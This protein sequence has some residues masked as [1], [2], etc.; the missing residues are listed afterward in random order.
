MVLFLM[1]ACKTIWPSQKEN[2]ITVASSDVA[3]E[4]SI[5]PKT[6]APTLP[7]LPAPEYRLARPMVW[8]QLHT[9]LEL[10][11]NASQKMVEGVATLTLS[12][13]RESNLVEI[14]ALG[15]FFSS[16]KLISTDS[17]VAVVQQDYSDSMVMRLQLNQRLTNKDTI[18]LRF[19]YQARPSSLLERK[20]IERSDQQGLYFINTDDY[21]K[22]VQQIWSQG[23]TTSNSAWF[24]CIDAPNQKTTQEVVLTV[25]TP[26]V[27]LSNGRLVY[28]VINRDGTRTF[29]WKQDRPHAPY[30]NMVAIGPFSI[31]ED[32]GP[33]QLPLYYYVE[34]TYAKH[35]R[36]IF[37]KTPTIISYFNQ[38]FGYKYPWDKYAQVTVR[39][40]V[41]GAMENTSATTMMSAIQHDS[42]QHN[43]YNYEDYI[44]HE[45]AHQWFGNLVTCESWANTALNEGFATYGEYLW[46]ANDYDSVAAF[47]KLEA[48]KRG[49]MAQ[50]Q[51]N[52]HPLIHYTYKGADGQM[53]DR[54]SYN[55]GALVI[56][57]LRRFL[58]DELFFACIASYLKE[59]EYTAVDVDHLRHSFE[60][61]SGLD[62]TA[63]FDSWFHEENHPI[64]DIKYSMI[65]SSRELG[66]DIVQKQAEA[67]YTT[68]SL[69]LPLM[70]EYQNGTKVWKLIDLA[71]S[72]R[73]LKVSL[74]GPIAY[75]G[76]STS[77]YPLI[78]LNEEKNNS[79]WLKGLK[80]KNLEIHQRSLEHFVRTWDQLKVSTKST[81]VAEQIA[82][83]RE[84]PLADKGLLDAVEND[85]NY[86]DL[87]PLLKSDNYPLKAAVIGYLSAHDQLSEAQ[88][89]DYLQ[90]PSYAVKSAAIEACDKRYSKRLESE[91]LK[92]LPANASYVNRS[93]A[94]LFKKHGSESVYPVFESIVM[95][96]HHS[97]K[98]YAIY[99][100]KRS[101]D[102]ILGRL[103]FFSE[104]KTAHD[105]P[106]SIIIDALTKLKSEIQA[107]HSVEAAQE[108]LD[109]I[110]KLEADLG[111]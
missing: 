49:Y 78:E 80:Q 68:Y 59:R 39:N 111:L 54:H 86:Y 16:V 75:V 71:Q 36:M 17:M 38:A 26:L 81:V 95:K 9:K 62:L 31:L 67:G 6:T 72:R 2:S 34:P 70:I 85:S 7:I 22:D 53:F 28:M 90:M 42:I 45:I 108:L 18:K 35:A 79:I 92:N 83:G 37:E 32:V 89:L 97:T 107:N 33:N 51:Y 40:F 20:K 101:K 103:K 109:A 13:H 1:T 29:R 43:D 44:V 94:E 66:I 106:D 76:I 10:S 50:S 99:L 12:P 24:P 84:S 58:G 61:T 65:D 11:F 15:M 96:N 41:S 21:G 93:A 102:F 77:N 19:E 52:V 64:L 105:W 73:S 82:W 5:S 98:R 110:D 27:A 87:S 46:I 4:D 91:I 60:S 23:E 57:T 74:D 69:S 3:T 104:L 30:L 88:L 48:L 25:D 8:K 56:H 47:E 63:F 55:K 14:D 100:S